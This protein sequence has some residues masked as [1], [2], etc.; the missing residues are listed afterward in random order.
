MPGR[1]VEKRLEIDHRV[2]TIPYTLYVR[3]LGE[4]EPAQEHDVRVR[5]LWEFSDTQM[6]LSGWYTGIGEKALGYTVSVNYPVSSA[7]PR[8]CSVS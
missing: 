8:S 3:G 6:A 7:L 5:A 4:L 2:R 1:P